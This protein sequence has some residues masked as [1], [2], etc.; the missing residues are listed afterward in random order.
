M[1]RFIVLV[2]QASLQEAAAWED[3]GF[4]VS[5]GT[6]HPEVRR[7]TADVVGFPWL[8]VETDAEQA[9]PDVVYWQQGAAGAAGWHKVRQLLPKVVVVMGEASLPPDLAHVYDSCFLYGEGRSFMVGRKIEG[10]LL[11]PE[12]AA[13]R[14]DG[15]LSLPQQVKAVADAVYRLL[16]DNVFQETAE[17]CGHMSSVVGPM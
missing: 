5:D 8:T 1:R 3:S 12:W 4:V 16:L 14:T 6:T 11:T 7:Q 10:T 13:Y 9:R 15:L 17:W 2:C